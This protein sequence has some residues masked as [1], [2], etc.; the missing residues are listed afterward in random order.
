MKVFSMEQGSGE[1]NTVRLGKVTASEI[2]S[3]VSPEGKV[4]TGEGPKT[5][6]YRK[7]S[8]K[9]LGFA[10][11]SGNTPAMEFGTI[12]QS[13]ALP[14]LAFTHDLPVTEVGFVADDSLR[15]GCSPD[16]LI[17]EDGGVEIKCCQPAKSLQYLLDGGV[18]KEH[19]LQVQFSMYVTGRKWWYF[20]SYSRQWPQ[21]LVK[22]YPDPVIHAAFTDA[23][24]DFSEKF[25]SAYNRIT[26]MRD[27]ENA[28]KSAAYS[29]GRD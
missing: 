29:G 13:E 19:K 1:W 8:E 10:A 18:P 12:R 15:Y 7:L 4:R 24:A 2:D 27:A 3:L 5:Y 9:I 11:D 25:D 16:G 22:V 6:L 14:W 26:S 28:I 23:L 21:L 20:L 17:G